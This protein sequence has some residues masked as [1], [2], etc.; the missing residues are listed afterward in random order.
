MAEPTPEID[1]L[2]SIYTSFRQRFPNV[3]GAL[4]GL[5][6]AGDEAGPLD[7]RERRLVT[8]GIAIGGLARGAVR[9]NVRKAI[10]LGVTPEEIRHVAVLA[11]TTGG[12][13][14]AV[15]GYEWI[16]EVLRDE[17]EGPEGAR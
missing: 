5:G 3:A 8:L 4:D 10:E 12:F 17:V 9:S 7:E 15:A 16:E 11:V 2:P 13:P 14:T 6:A 1:H